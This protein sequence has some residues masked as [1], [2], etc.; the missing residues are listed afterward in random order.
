MR[1]I[2]SYTDTCFYP[3]ERANSMVK[4]SR[5]HRAVLTHNFYHYCGTCASCEHQRNETRNRTARYYFLMALE[6]DTSVPR[7]AIL[8]FLI[9]PKA[10]ADINACQL[11]TAVVI[12]CLSSFPQLFNHSKTKQKPAWKPTDTYYR[13]LKSRIMGNNKE[14]TAAHDISS[15]ISVPARSLPQFDSSRSLEQRHT[16]YAASYDSLEMAPEMPQQIRQPQQ[17]E[18]VYVAMPHPSHQQDSQSVSSLG[19]CPDSDTG[20][21]EKNQI[22]RHITYS[23]TKEPAIPHCHELQ[24]HIWENKNVHQGTWA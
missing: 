10:L 12:A 2:F 14:S 15:I 16:H 23:V 6:C 22:T 24:G 8:R 9:N 4:E 3:L 13:R 5:V 21:P 11:L 18:H 20:V 19:A 1:N 17:A 7:Y